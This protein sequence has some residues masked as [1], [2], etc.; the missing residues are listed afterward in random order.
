MKLKFAHVLI[1]AWF[2]LIKV[3]SNKN[4]DYKVGVGI[5]DVTGP[6]AEIGMVKNTTIKKNYSTKYV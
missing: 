5:S 6:A 4:G 3:A 1:I 2:L